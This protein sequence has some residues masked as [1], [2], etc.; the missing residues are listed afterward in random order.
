M[1]PLNPGDFAR[2]YPHDAYAENLSRDIARNSFIDFAT[3]TYSEYYPEPFHVQLAGILERVLTGD[4]KRLMIFAPPQ[5]GKSELTSVRFP[6]YWIAKKPRLPIILA[7]YGASLA[8]EKA[9]A[10][11]NIVYSQEYYNLF[12]HL[13][14]EPPHAWKKRNSKYLLTIGGTKLYATGVRGA[15]TGRG[16]GLGIIDDPVKDWREAYSPNMRESTWQW[17]RGTFRT[18]IWANGR[19]VIIMCMTGDTPVLMG[20][21]TNT[22][23]RDIKV[24]DA[25]AT[26]KD[27]CLATSTIKNWI[28][29]GSDLVYGITTISGK[30]VK[31]NERH[32]FLINRNGEQQWVR[33]KDLQVGDKMICLKEHGQANNVPL[34][35]A[36]NLQ[37]VKD[38][39]CPTT[40]KQDGLTGIVLHQPTMNQERV[41]VSK[42]G[43]ALALLNINPNLSNRMADALY[44]EAC[45][46]VRT[47]QKVGL[48]YSALTTIMKQESLEAC[49]ATTAISSSNMG[50]LKDCFSPQSSIYDFGV[51]EIVSI[52]SAGY[53]D[54]FDIEVEGTHN[55]ISNGYVSSN[56]RWHEDDLAG[57]ILNE[58][59]EK[60]SVIRY[61]AIAET[62]ILRSE[63]EEKYLKGAA[64]N[65]LYKDDPLEREEGDALC[66]H[67]F[68]LQSLLDIQHDVG[69]RAWAAEYQG[70]PRP[71]EGNL[72]QKEWIHL[73]DDYPKDE[74]GLYVRYWDKAG[75][76][77][78]G[79]KTAGLLM[80]M[81][82][83]KTWYVVDVVKGQWSV[84][85]REEIIKQTAE[86][87]KQMYGRIHTWIEME[88]GSGGKESAMATIKNLAGFDIRAEKVHDSKPTRMEPASRQ[89]EAGNIYILN[90]AWTWELVD[91]LL[92]WPHGAFK[93]QGDAFS[94]AFRKCTLSGWS[95]SGS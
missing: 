23:L 40:I 26:Y 68:P 79:A 22:M 18:R 88:P 77:G 94:G 37:N 80:G 67:R 30:M 36:N 48:L 11:Q 89:M 63:I 69:P 1:L 14:K 21:G 20:D 55:F 28:N 35:D 85:Q 52:N 54:V 57:R 9:A 27:G 75:T 83:Q 70:T 24:G 65:L 71:L 78:G 34:L 50:Q 84:Y 81:T 10:A 8:W 64:K 17:W 49:S 95:R 41:L 5:H 2:K 7:S 86:R 90:R 25:V 15:I 93:D 91:E 4:I 53:E 62:P 45:P 13:F 43:M 33:L 82:K 16:A 51:D 76:E 42:T 46:P 31:A 38:S 92:M 59:G 44:A 74:I 6:A 39:A 12:P 3:Y 47:L 32:P 72:I 56:T 73:V 19:I 87:D 60:W 29:Q 61:P 66:P 58:S